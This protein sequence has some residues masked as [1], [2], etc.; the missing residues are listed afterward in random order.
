MPKTLEGVKYI[1]P[2][3]KYGFQIAGRQVGA[4]RYGGRFH[5]TYGMAL[6]ARARCGRELIEKA[7]GS[8]AIAV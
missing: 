4:L 3:Q 5:D 7:D 6:V 1:I 8:T 2:Y